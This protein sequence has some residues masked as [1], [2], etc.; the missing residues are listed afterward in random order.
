MSAYGAL[1]DLVPAAS[2]FALR[3]EQ[4]ATAPYI[5]YREISTVPLNTKGDSQDTAAD[6]RIRQRSILDTSRVQISVFAD[7]Y[8]DVENIA[9]KVREA[10]DREWGSVNS[11][12]ENDVSLDSLVFES[13]VDDFDDDAA[14]RGLYIKHLDFILRVTRLNI[15]NTWT[16]EYSLN[17]DGVDDYVTFGDDAKWSINGSGG[18]RGFSISIWVKLADVQTSWII[19]KSGVYDSGA[20]RYEWELLSRFNGQVRFKMFFNDSASNYIEFDSEQQ[21]EAATWYHIV[22]T[23]DLS[24]AATGLNMYIDNSLKN[25][26]NAEATVSLTG[27]WGTVSNTV[28]PMYLARNSGVDYAALKLDEYSIWDEVLTADDV[29]KLYNSG[30]TGDPNRYPVSSNYL[31]GYWRCGD[32]ATFSTIPDAAPQYSNNGEMVN[33]AAD[34]INT[35]VPT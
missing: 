35:D 25:T 14:S 1:T 6:P 33:M 30:K 29:S 28:N 31:V 19:S 21:L 24:Q 18:N 3:A 9:V 17:F 13:S 15:S 16:N 22:I 32:G 12:Y 10:L 7:T 27:S 34:D 8:L 5:V 20:N 4:P 2:M 26:T 11:P 23:Y